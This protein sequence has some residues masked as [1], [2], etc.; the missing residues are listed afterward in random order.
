MLTTDTREETQK[1]RL[2]F[3]SALFEEQAARHA[4]DAVAHFRQITRFYALFHMGYFVVG[5]AELLALLLFLPFFAKSSLLAFSLA[6]VFLT[7][8]SYF[9][10]RFYFQAKKPEQLAQL[11]QRFIE[12]CKNALP[13]SLDLSTYHLSLTHAVYRLIGRLDSQERQYYQIP[14]QF[15]TLAPLLEKF[16]LWCHWKDVHQMKEMLHRYC[17]QQRIELV[18]AQP[19]DLEVHASLANSYIALYKEYL[20]KKAFPYA[21]IAREYASDAMRE[22]FQSI[23]KRAVEEFKII[24]AYAPND[25]WVYAQLAV[26]YHDLNLP[27]KETEAYETLLRIAPQDRELLFRCGLL[28]FQQGK[29]AQGLKVYEQLKKVK[30]PKADEL[31]AYYDVR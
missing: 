1:S 24:D 30:D 6:A 20:A 25:P 23:A 17:I 29:T 2:I 26:I 9:V 14:Q 27:E 16:S 21:F 7:G 19:T 31:I 15:Q 13:P 5:F 22:K 28:Y 18:K 12:A 10:L 3:N 8:F 11:K 4:D